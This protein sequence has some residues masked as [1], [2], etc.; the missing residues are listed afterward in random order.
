M[1]LAKVFFCFILV[2]FFSNWVFARNIDLNSLQVK[3]ATKIIESWVLKISWNNPVVIIPVNDRANLNSLLKIK[4]K[5]KNYNQN[6]VGI[7]FWRTDL[8]FNKDPQK[9]VQLSSNPNMSEYKINLNS[10]QYFEWSI[11]YIA[12]IFIWNDVVEIEGVDLDYTGVFEGVSM[13]LSEIFTYKPFNP[14]TINF[15]EW[16]MWNWDYINKPIVKFLFWL[17]WISIV[18]YFFNWRHFQRKIIYF[19]VWIFIFFW[20]FLDL[21]STVNQVKM[22]NDFT[23]ANNIMENW[24]LWKNSN[25]YQ[26]LDFIRKNTERW[27]RWIF[28]AQYPFTFEWKYH[29]YPDVKFDK[30]ENVDYILAYNPKGLSYDWSWWVL[31]YKEKKYNVDKVK[32]FKTYAKIYYI[33][34]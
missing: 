17:M 26:Y 29:I 1:R 18:L 4:F 15:L 2:A 27:N 11:S 13:K 24:R 34:K 28:L 31:T 9:M 14:R 21:L 12:V 5:R 33:K 32:E 23:S 22:Y 3:N 25:F 7:Q 30:I 10:I 20:V 16:P 8:K 19:N 6:N